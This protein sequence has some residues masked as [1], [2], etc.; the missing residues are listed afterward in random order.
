MTYYFKSGPGTDDV[1][2]EYQR[3]LTDKP[4]IG[5][6]RTV[7]GSVSAL[8]AKFY[9]LMRFAIGE[10]WGKDDPTLAIRTMKIKGDGFHCWTEV[11]I[12]TFEYR[13]PIGTRER[14]ALALLLYTG[15]RR[16]DVIHMGRQHIANGPIQLVQ[17]K[18]K[19]QLSIPIHPELQR[20]MDGTPS[21]H[22]TFLCT[23]NGKPFTAPGFGNW[24]REAYDT[25]NVRGCS[26]HGLRKAAARRLAEA[27]CSPHQIASI[28]GH[29]T[30]KRWSTTPKRPIKSGLPRMPCGP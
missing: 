20:V 1:L 11:E 6:D 3:W 5:A 24:F 8:I 27:G 9:L 22:L 18:T 7:S 21:D 25:A 16:G 28:T 10:E 13:W 29:K 30:L 12:A 15:Q 2:I 17:H 26:A 19:A 23:S 14:L 4:E